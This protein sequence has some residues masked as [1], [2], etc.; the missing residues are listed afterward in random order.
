[1]IGLEWG[2][3]LPALSLRILKWLDV[4]IS[5]VVV[6]RVATRAP[7]VTRPVVSFPSAASAT[8]VCRVV[9]VRPFVCRANV[10]RLVVIGMM[11]QKTTTADRA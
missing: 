1:M 5:P 7:I 3:S 10:A 2:V 9:R 8:S 11:A 4:K 6:T